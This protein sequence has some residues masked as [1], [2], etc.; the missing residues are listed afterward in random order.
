MQSCAAWDRQTHTG[1]W[2]NVPLCATVLSLTSEFHSGSKEL[3]TSDY[4]ARFPFNTSF[5][6]H[7]FSQLWSCFPAAISFPIDDLHN[8]K[9]LKSFFSFLMNFHWAFAVRSN[10][11]LVLDFFMPLGTGWWMSYTPSPTFYPAFQKRHSISVTQ[12]KL[13]KI[14]QG[15]RGDPC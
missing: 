3:W 13:Q 1:A 4:V 11:S 2:L 5:S 8:W 6:L 7:L 14:Q 15:L 10:N 12:T 9:A